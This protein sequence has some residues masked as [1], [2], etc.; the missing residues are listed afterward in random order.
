ML[1][2]LHQQPHWILL[3]LLLHR[4]LYHPPLFHLRMRR[5]KRKEK[6]DINAKTT[7]TQVNPNHVEIFPTSPK[8]KIQREFS[9]RRIELTSYTSRWYVWLMR[10]GLQN[11]RL[12]CCALLFVGML[13]HIFLPFCFR[14][15]SVEGLA[16]GLGVRDDRRKAFGT[17]VGTGGFGRRD[18]VGY[19]TSPTPHLQES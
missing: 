12:T 3:F 4:H 1:P 14:M 9:L 10:K 6:E 5:K 2:S 13:V 18:A 16:R 17:G 11:G 15:G 19:R 7:L 8:E